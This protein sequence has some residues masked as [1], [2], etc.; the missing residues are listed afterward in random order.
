MGGLGRWA[1]AGLLVAFAGQTARAA[2]LFGSLSEEEAAPVSDQIELGTGWYLRGDA[3]GGYDH[4][5]NIAA[6]LSNKT[7]MA[8]WSVDLGA[9]YK[10]NNWLRADLSVDMRKIQSSGGSS[11]TLADGVSPIICPYVLQGLTTQG[12]NPVELG[13]LWST[14]AGTCQ[15]NSS[16]QVRAMSVF[17]NGYVDLG[18]WAGLTPY[19]G[20]GIGLAQLTTD[21]S[22]N[23]TKTSDGSVYNTDLTP[24]GTYPLIWT[25]VSGNALT[26]QPTVPNTTKDV[27]FGK[28]NWNSA[29]RSTRYN[30]AWALMAGVGYALND[31][32]QLDVGFRYVNLGNLKTLNSTTSSPLTSKEVRVG[33]RYLID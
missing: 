22:V 9:G 16:A 15:Q 30:F 13:Y 31:R 27:A 19:V 14:Q 18:T 32:A 21:A 11:L 25:D 4:V 20:A 17:L 26:P 28:Q 7:R 12:A 33:I 1:M 10:F 3:G 29:Q 24:T 8:T 23:Y 2:D 5:P 6:N